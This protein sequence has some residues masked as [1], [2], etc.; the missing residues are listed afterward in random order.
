MQF[1]RYVPHNSA[2]D[3]RTRMSIHL[4]LALSCISVYIISMH[5]SISKRETKWL[6]KD[7]NR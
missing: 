1:H 6:D 3:L 7:V 5:L 4:S 2:A